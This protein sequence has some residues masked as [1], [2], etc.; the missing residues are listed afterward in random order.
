MKVYSILLSLCFV[1]SLTFSDVHAQEET[2]QAQPEQQVS[3][4]LDSQYAQL[5]K[6]ANT[7]KEWKLIKPANMDALWRQVQD[8][9]AAERQEIIQIQDKLTA[10]Q[11]QITTL[12][13]ELKSKIA[14][15][16]Q[17]DYI[18]VLGID[19]KKHNYIT[20]NWIVIFVLVVLL[21]VAV[22]KFNASNKLAVQKRKE[23]EKVEEELKV[24]R[25]K[26]QEKEIQLRRE[27]VTERNKAEELQQKIIA[28]KK[29]HRG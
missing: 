18:N 2:T 29:D 5:K 23:S 3:N 27:L 19:L 8:S 17:S 11:K 4:T 26:S 28:L 16:E 6:K 9:L 1:L 22:I 14:E 20:F 24:V 13:D 15:L 7:W 21:V 25:K 10:S 12:N